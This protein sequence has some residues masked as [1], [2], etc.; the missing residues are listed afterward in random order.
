MLNTVKNPV[1]YKKLSSNILNR[2]VRYARIDTESKDNSDTYP[3]TAKQL[4]LLKLLHKELK[5][6]GIK[7]TLDKYGYVMA[8]IPGNLPKQNKVPAI[9]L[10]AHV[11]TAPG[12][13]GKNVKP[14]II[15]NYR[16]GDI[17]LPGAKNLKIKVKENPG[18][19]KQIGKTIITSDGTTLLGADNKA[20]VAI[21][22]ALAE[23]LIKNSDLPHGDIK[24]CFTPDEEVGAGTKYFDIK[25]FG[26]K[27]AYTID[28]ELAPDL[29]KETFSANSAIITIEGKDIH[30]GEA[31][32][33]M[34]NA[35]RIAGDIIAR[36]PKNKAPETTEGYE[37]YIHPLFVEGAISK[38]TIKL[39]FRDF[40]TS[41]LTQLKKQVEKIIHDVKKLYPKAKI[42]LEIIHSY[43]NMH[44]RL[45]KNP[46][47]IRYL[48]MAA[49]AAGLSPQWKPVRGGT[50][51]AF[52]T[53]RGLLTPNIFSGSTNHH[54]LTEWASLYEMTKAA[55]TVL[56]LVQIFPKEL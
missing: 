25:K 28:G 13:S 5:A 16:G 44:D 10:I 56:N 30:P 27:Y 34:I 48:E 33:V 3:S 36:L 2:F 23:L 41:G 53:A 26:A 35:T 22:M 8:S 50:D 54:G 49:K 4:I 31:K 37:P 32:N 45:Q 43:R 42:N 11:D 55:E 46:R 52:L 47:V 39:L 21:I 15:Q 51:G 6:I 40:K 38:A 12:I 20:G 14:Q 18:L 9:G 24:I 7:A 1:D 29:N 19:K 17:A